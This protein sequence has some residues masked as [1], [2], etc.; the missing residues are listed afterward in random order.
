M[1]FW[2]AFII[3]VLCFEF[4][5]F[6]FLIACWPESLGVRQPDT[7]KNKTILGFQEACGNSFGPSILKNENK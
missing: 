2:A 4:Y 6:I 3:L 5:F 7:N 1:F